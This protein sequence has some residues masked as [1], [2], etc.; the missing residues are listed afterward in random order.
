MRLNVLAAIRTP[1]G[2]FLGVFKNTKATNLCEELIK[3]VLH[4]EIESIY[5]GC[6][7]S[8]GLGQA[9]ARQAAIGAGIS[10]N[11][12]C[13]VVNKVCG[14]GMQAAIMAIQDILTSQTRISIACG[15]ESMSNAPYL[16]KD[17]RVGHKFGNSKNIDHMI[18]DGLE[19]AYSHKLMGEIADESANLYGI[20][21]KEQEEFVL[22]T[23][24]NALAAN[25]A[26]EIVGID[27]VF[28]DETIKKVIIEKFNKLKPAFKKDGTI[29]AATASSIADGA[30]LICIADPDVKIPPIG[31]IVG[32]CIYSGNPELFTTAPIYAITGLLDKINWDINDVDLFEINEAF[33][34]VPIIAMKELKIPREKININ[35]GACVLGHPIGSSGIRIIVTLLHAL[36]IYNK[37]RGIA[38]ICI[39]GG[40]A[41]AIAVESAL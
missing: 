1:H 23:Y 40:E 8:A 37:K 19:D 27:G 34:I 22:Q 28:E 16:I 4:F 9:P 20:P 11:V 33:A 17:I 15:M 24:K 41:I 36:K 38:C 21:R 6:V 32:Y 5:V 14:S 18:H 29:T 26:N 31:F 35:G 39:G 30:S 25:F 10:T 3:R 13:A 7:L 12:P 2:S